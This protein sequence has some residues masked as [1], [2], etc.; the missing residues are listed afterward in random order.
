MM[1]IYVVKYWDDADWCYSTVGY[2][3]SKKLAEEV[4]EKC[5]VALDEDGDLVYEDIEF[6]VKEIELDKMPC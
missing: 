1:K 2:Y 3:S 4:I 6:E 5:K